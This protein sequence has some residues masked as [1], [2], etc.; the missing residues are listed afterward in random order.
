MGLF[1]FPS[2]LLDFSF[3]PQG[4]GY[5][6][7]ARPGLQ[8]RCHC[9]WVQW[10]EFDSH[11]LPPIYSIISIT[12]FPKPH[13]VG[14]YIK[15]AQSK[16][17]LSLSSVDVVICVILECALAL[18]AVFSA[19]NIFITT[20]PLTWHI[21]GLFFHEYRCFVINDATRADSDNLY[22]LH[23]YAINNPEFSYPEASIPC[24]LTLKWFPLSWLRAYLI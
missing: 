22:L 14:H 23:C 15:K 10:G 20:M 7:G 16:K 19:H 11:A 12:C 6:A 3:F 13:T 4:R 1:D 8:S 2:M 5:G 24:Q 18:H 17:P 9:A 21:F